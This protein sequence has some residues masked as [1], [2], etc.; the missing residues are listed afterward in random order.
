MSVPASPD[1]DGSAT[2][3]R[4]LP[5]SHA[6]GHGDE[7]RL[8]QILLVE[9]NPADIEL[10]RQA[11]TEGRVA[12]EVHVVG[13]GEEAM[14]FLRQQGAHAAAPR[15]DLVLLD[16][17]LPRKD[18]RQVLVELKGDE[19]LC[20]IPVVVLTT[21]AV[22]EDIL[23]AYRQ[24]VNSYIRKPVRLDELIRVVCSIDEYWLGIVA[25]PPRLVRPREQPQA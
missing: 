24:H 1:G 19:D 22:D 23:H 5:R 16:L 11:L 12:N 17:N 7:A 21:S 9:D 13:D 20:T 25:L 6:H 18:G 3:D 10:T 4:V 8:V 2:L 14:G 15:P